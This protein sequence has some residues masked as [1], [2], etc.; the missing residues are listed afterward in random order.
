[1]NNHGAD[2]TC[3]QYQGEFWTGEFISARE[4]MAPTIGRTVEPSL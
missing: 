2:V 1:M 3:I 4:L